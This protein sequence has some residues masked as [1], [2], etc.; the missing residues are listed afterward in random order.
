MR[1]VVDLAQPAGVDVAVYLGRRERAVAEQLL[2]RAQ[3]GAA[4]EQVRREGVAQ[5]V[6][7]W[8]QA[9]E[10]A[11]VEPA[12][13]RREEE[14]VLGSARELRTRVPQVGRHRVRGLLA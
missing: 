6:R 7:V 5:P 8:Q 12:A 4:L 3:V 13:T 11:R 14:R 2:D 1:A 9:A 10:R